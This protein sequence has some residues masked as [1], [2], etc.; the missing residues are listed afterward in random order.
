MHTH[1]HTLTVALLLMNDGL[2]VLGSLGF[3]E[4]SELQLDF[5]MGNYFTDCD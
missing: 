3:S 5:G 1:T 4:H 2:L